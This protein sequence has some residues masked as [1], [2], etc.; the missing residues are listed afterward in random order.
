VRAL[1]LIIIELMQKYIKDDSA[2]SINNLARW[3]F[4]C[5]AVT[6]LLYTILAMFARELQNVCGL[7]F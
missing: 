5:N 2:I 6:F 4:D 1:S 7:L 3:P